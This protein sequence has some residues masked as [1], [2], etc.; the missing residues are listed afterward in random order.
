[1][2][3]L[4]SRYL[5]L[6]TSSLL[7][8]FSIV[9]CSSDSPTAV[10]SARVPT[11]SVSTSSDDA[12]TYLVRFKSNA[13]P[14]DF[15]SKV[16]ALGGQVIFSHKV[17][18]AAVAG[19]TP[20]A[21]DQLAANASVAGVDPDGLTYLEKPASVTPE[22]ADATESP[23][24]PALASRFSRQWNMKTI[25]AD[26]A[27]AHGKK[28]D[29]SVEVGI[30][31]TGIDYLA[32][33]LVGRVDMTLSH[34]FLSTT[35][36]NRV[37]TTFGAGTPPWV[38]LYFHGTHVAAT[39]AS[40]AYVYAGV[41]SKT[42]LVSLRACAPGSAADGFASSCPTSAVLNAIL[43]AADNHIPIINMSLGGGFS[44]RDASARGGFGPSFIA[45]INRIMNYADKNGTTVIVA[46]GNGDA[47]GIGID[48]DH[49]GNGYDAYCNATTVICVSA[50]GPTGAA[51]SNGPWANIDALASYSN[52]GRSAI[53]VA[54]PGG[55]VVP[56]TAACSGFTI[57]TSFLVCR[58]RYFNSPTSYLE[59]TIGAAGTSM[60][61]PHVA[62]VAAL[63]AANGVTDPAKIRAILEQTADDLGQPG[64][65]PAYGHGRINAARAAGVIQ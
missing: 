54:A 60:A 2:S 52:Y 23:N 33:D 1:M 61:T 65:D 46:A 8:S 44:R 27:W 20:D 25:Q 36:N 57:I 53:S 17:G 22:L 49:D 37:T 55:Y 4:S 38:D 34:S 42:K 29:A 15:E 10:S 7:A 9:A 40:N 5:P 63:I 11:M 62:G 47:H 31:D 28:G 48:L 30:I 3:R 41:T 51:G 6:L 13:V 43:Y 24:S 58:T 18:I 26:S 64:V 12:G 35:E 19:L 45:T 59:Y 32:P 56:V 50:T 21:A 39:V 14:S 16:N